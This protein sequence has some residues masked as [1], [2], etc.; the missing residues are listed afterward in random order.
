MPEPATPQKLSAGRRW[1]IRGLLVL[2]TLVAVVAIFAVWANRQGLDAANWSDTSAQLLENQDVQDQL[3]A[4]LVDTAYSNIDVAGTLQTA[5]PP[6]LAPIAGPA[7]S[8]LRQLA[9]NRT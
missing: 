6:R 4:F 5:L 2:A 9:E 3:A 1:A 8:G 7:A